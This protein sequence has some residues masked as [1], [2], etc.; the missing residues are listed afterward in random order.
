MGHFH[1]MTSCAVPDGE[2][3]VE[4]VS[5]PL[6]PGELDGKEL[7]V[8][9]GGT[10]GRV[11]IGEYHIVMDPESINLMITN[12]LGDTTVDVGESQAPSITM[13]ETHSD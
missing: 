10:R 12:P 3:L 7:W 5:V 4:P 13:Q 2:W 9:Y 6:Q 8:D 11:Q 1:A